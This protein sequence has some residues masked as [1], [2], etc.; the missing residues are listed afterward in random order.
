MSAASESNVISHAAIWRTVLLAWMIWTIS[1]FIYRIFFHPLRHVPGPKLAA[2]TFW[3][4][5]YYEVVK[6]ARYT[7]KIGELHGQYNSPIIRINPDEVHINDPEY[8]DTIYSQSRRRVDKPPKS[9]DSFGPVPATFGTGD[10]DLHR[11]RRAPLNKHFSKKSVSDLQPGI[12]SSIKKLCER[13]ERASDEGKTVNLKYAYAAV[14]R[15]IID[16]YCFSRPT[17]SVLMEDFNEEYTETLEAGHHM[18]PIVSVAD[19]LLQYG[20]NIPDHFG[21]FIQFRWLG[22]LLHALPAWVTKILDPGFGKLLDE[23]ESLSQQVEAMRAGKYEAHKSSYHPTVLQDLLE[24][25]M[26]EAE[27]TKD[28]IK[29]EA[30]TLVGAGTSTVAMVLMTT[31]CHLVANPPTRQKLFRELYSAMPDPGMTDL[32]LQNLEQLPYLT[33]VILEGHRL[34]HSAS[35]RLLRVFPSDTLT[36]GTTVIAP[37]TTVS[38]TPLLVHENPSLFPSPHDFKPER[39]LTE[40]AQR[41]KRF[42]VPF[43]KGTRQCI[44]L[45]LAQAEL[46]MG[47]AMVFR[48]FS[49]D[50]VDVKR[51][52]DYEVCRDTVIGSMRKDSKGVVVK[53]RKASNELRDIQGWL[54]GRNGVCDIS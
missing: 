23:M 25:D 48:R 54:A 15:D 29:A 16:E 14:A 37:G 43:G 32:S 47:L 36:Y 1:R 34:S 50:F 38:M 11:I 31:T 2:L 46:Y 9:S 44:G 22:Y 13:L 33:A 52:R 45:N 8:Y 4:E 40:D 35:H 6:P 7:W 18:T 20:V 12:L 24:S 28:R 21:Q 17:D 5:T 10:H 19:K 30:Q 41:L 51:E 3:Y 42:L 39:W 26:P 53:V 27:K 49:F